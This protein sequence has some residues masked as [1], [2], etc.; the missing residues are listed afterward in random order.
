MPEPKIEFFERASTYVLSLLYVEFPEKTIIDPSRVAESLFRATDADG[1]TT[2]DS[3]DP[4]LTV[5][6]T[7]SYLI[8]EGF[9]RG[10]EQPLIDGWSVFSGC[11]LSERGLKLLAAVP[12]TV[13]LNAE[14]RR[15]GRRLA[16]AVENGAWSMG[17]QLIR[18]LFDLRAG[19]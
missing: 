6:A 4:A 11:R 17:A 12:A 8:D 7:I 1:R 18:E 15:P 14:E 10:D 9:V 5:S 2:S 19:S 3:F 13:D 16:D